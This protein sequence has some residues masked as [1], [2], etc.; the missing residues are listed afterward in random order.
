MGVVCMVVMQWTLLV[1]SHGVDCQVGTVIGEVT[2]HNV[3]TNSVK[4][5]NGKNLGL[6][7]RVLLI[8]KLG[9]A[10]EEVMV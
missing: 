4:S 8:L 7:A 10:G 9:K 6:Q 1:P 2:S 3:I 5:V